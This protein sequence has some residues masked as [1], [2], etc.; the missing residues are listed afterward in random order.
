MDLFIYVWILI[1]ALYWAAHIIRYG[2]QFGVIGELA[3]ALPFCI[4]FALPYLIG[5]VLIK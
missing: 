1:G 4:L 5:K 2:A 3:V